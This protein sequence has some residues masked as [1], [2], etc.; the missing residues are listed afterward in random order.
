MQERTPLDPPEQE[1]EGALASLAPSLTGISADALWYHARIVSE[2]RRGN[3]WRAAAA[4]AI[5]AAGGAFLWRSAPRT[6]TVDRMVVVRDYQTPA[7]AT[8]PLKPSI[9]LADPLQ[10]G[11]D[12][13]VSTA[14][15][16]LRDSLAANGPDSLPATAAGDPTDAA[17]PRAGPLT[18]EAFDS[19]AGSRHTYIRGG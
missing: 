14:Y 9:S 5:L 6:V 2:R 4:I 7:V 10:A 15:L 12:V 19:L 3:H 1:L 13:R 16:R 8:F 18:A 17:V 11:S